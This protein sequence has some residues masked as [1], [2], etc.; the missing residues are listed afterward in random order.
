MVNSPIAL[1]CEHYT[2]MEN[3]FW[4]SSSP[5]DDHLQYMWEALASMGLTRIAEPRSCGSW[6]S[7]VNKQSGFQPTVEPTGFQ[8]VVVQLAYSS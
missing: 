8:P 1:S 3:L 7:S 5:S 4:N 2:N 6:V